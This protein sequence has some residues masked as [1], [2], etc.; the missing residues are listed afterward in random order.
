MSLLM[1]NL[2]QAFVNF[3][4]VTTNLANP[5]GPPPTPDEVASAAQNFRNVAYLDAGYLAC[6]GMYCVPCDSC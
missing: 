3:G 6:I 5:S 4:A 1:G 2:T